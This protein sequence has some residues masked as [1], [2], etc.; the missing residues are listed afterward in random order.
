MLVENEKNR[1]LYSC[2]LGDLAFEWQ[3]GWRWPCFDTDLSA[4]IMQMHLVSMW[5]AWFT[6]Q[7]Q[8]GLYQNKVTASLTAIQR[9]GHWA[10]NCKMV[11]WL[12]HK[13]NLSALETYVECEGVKCTSCTSL[14]SDHG[15]VYRSRCTARYDVHHTWERT[16]NGKWKPTESDVQRCYNSDERTDTS[17]QTHLNFIFIDSLNNR[18]WYH[19]TSISPYSKMAVILVFFCLLWN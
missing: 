14:Y 9:P 1:P 18:F 13:Y 12:M 10:E 2:L 8:W 3:W 16:T 4:F 11:Y 6:Q 5:T 7:K 17:E 19:P 15:N